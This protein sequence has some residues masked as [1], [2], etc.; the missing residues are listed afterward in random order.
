MILSPGSIV[1]FMDTPVN[2]K[3]P[4]NR[5]RHVYIRNKSLPILKVHA[6][7]TFSLDIRNR[8]SIIDRKSS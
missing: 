4:H 7:E 8:I 3:V 2:I 6:L 5:L 1:K